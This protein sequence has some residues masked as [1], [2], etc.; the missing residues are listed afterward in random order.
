MKGQGTH[1]MATN[2]F[3]R[4]KKMAAYTRGHKLALYSNSKLQALDAPTV[5]LNSTHSPRYS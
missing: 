4:S 1:S 3:R 2:F 5:L